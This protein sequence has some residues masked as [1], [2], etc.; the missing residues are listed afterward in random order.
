[1]SKQG[2][3]KSTGTTI[4]KAIAALRKHEKALL[5]IDGVVGCDVGYRMRGGRLTD[6][7]CIR[8]W[9]SGPKKPEAY[10]RRTRLIPSALDSVPTDVVTSDGKVLA[11]MRIPYYSKRF[12]KRLHQ[13]LHGHQTLQTTWAELAW[14][15]M[16]VGRQ[17]WADVLQHGEHSLYESMYRAL[18]LY[19]NLKDVGGRLMKTAA[20]NGL[21]P[22]EKGAVSYFL[23]LTAGKLFAARL[24]GVPYVMHLGIYQDRFQP[25]HFRSSERPDLFGFDQSNNLLVMEAK[26]RSHGLPKKLMEKAKRQTRSLRKMGGI[27]PAIRVASGAHFAAGQLRVSLE[28]ATGANRSTFDLDLNLDDFIRD[29]YRGFVEMIQNADDSTEMTIAGRT[30]HVVSL[31]AVGI[32][33]GLDDLILDRFSDSSDLYRSIV[34]S[35]PSVEQPLNANRGDEGGVHDD[36]ATNVLT[37]PSDDP[38]AYYGPDGIAVWLPEGWRS[39]IMKM[40]PQ[41]RTQRRL[42]E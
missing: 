32:R 11:S 41:E 31:P 17:S 12:P 40:E 8:C 27:A 30:C 14:A 19:A 21:D 28:D 39:H 5:A 22:S 7:V 42:Q 6:E 36:A 24:L 38:L 13:T 29:Y 35:L 18:L 16:T 15:A 1:M 34:S 33:L 20:F 26:G 37:G 2:Q 9:I 23:G 4:N 3:R 10:L 25:V